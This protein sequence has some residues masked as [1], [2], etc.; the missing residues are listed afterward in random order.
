MVVVAIP[1][2]QCILLSELSNQKAENYTSQCFS[3]GY[4]TVWN[5]SEFLEK[6][7]S[8]APLPSRAELIKQLVCWRAHLMKIVSLVFVDESR[9]LISASSDGSVRYYS[10]FFALLVLGT[11]R[12]GSPRFGGS[13]LGFCVGSLYARKHANDYNIKNWLVNVKIS[14]LLVI[15]LQSRSIQ[16]LFFFCT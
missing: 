3:E 7:P 11:A 8:S 12:T 16:R 6:S 5:V 13:S 1:S 4:I 9:V 14:Q 10:N 2:E 15:T